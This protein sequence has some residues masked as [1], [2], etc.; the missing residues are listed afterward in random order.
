MRLLFSGAND[1][2]PSVGLV[3]AYFNYEEKDE[4]EALAQGNKIY[5]ERKVTFLIK[6]GLKI[7]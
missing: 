7:R 3:K 6:T 5:G 2:F 4:K 1:A